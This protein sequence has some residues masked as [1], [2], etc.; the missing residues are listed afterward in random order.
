[1]PAPLHA[2]SLALSTCQAPP[3]PCSSVLPCISALLQRD[4][5]IPGP[6]CPCLARGLGSMEVSVPGTHSFQGTC[7]SVRSRW[8]PF[9]PASCPSRSCPRGLRK[10][11]T[12]LLEPHEQ[13]CWRLPLALPAWPADPSAWL[14][15]T[16]AGSRGHRPLQNRGL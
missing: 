16:W 12:C 1:M 9:V 14:L 13:V 3:T 7:Q 6:H 11:P 2:S 4:C 5:P 8:F 10:A 15:S